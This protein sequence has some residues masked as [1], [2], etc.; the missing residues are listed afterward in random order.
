MIQPQATQ[1]P[2]TPSP[3]GETRSLLAEFHMHFPSSSEPCSPHGH[4]TP[5]RLLNPPTFPWLRGLRG[6][7]RLGSLGPQLSQLFPKLPLCFP[8]LLSEFIPRLS[9]L[10]LTCTSYKLEGFSLARHT[11]LTLLSHSGPPPPHPASWARVHSALF[12]AQAPCLR[13]YGP[14]ASGSR[15]SPPAA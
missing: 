10:P 8:P 6:L 1:A 13:E 7:N 5:E 4:L 14:L 12:D 15:Q 9:S 3:L 2:P 11:L